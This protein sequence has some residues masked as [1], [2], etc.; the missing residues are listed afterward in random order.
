MNPAGFLFAAWLASSQA[1]Q[2]QGDWHGAVQVEDDAPL[3][4]ALHVT[5]DSSGAL[6]ATL[7]SIDEDGTAL[8]VDSIAAKAAHVKFELKDIGGVFEGNVNAD[9]SAIVGA[10]AQNGTSW[11]LEWHR[12]EDPAGFFRPFGAE[13]ARDRARTSIQWF[14]GNEF[15]K[16]W[17]QF[18]PV[19][20]QAFGSPDQLRE[21]RA[22][23][24]RQYGGEVKILDEQLRN[25]DVLQTYCRRAKFSGSSG[26]IE[27]RLAI[28]ASGRITDF[29]IRPVKP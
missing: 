25:D 3:R 12:G 28:N 6:K 5:Q 2:I 26:E 10:W 24:L 4:L 14:Y 22:R 18:S 13:A 16:L 8:P 17:N 19:L 21:L 11:P 23:A 20:R 29:L 9:G 27:L 15:T 1:P 7:D